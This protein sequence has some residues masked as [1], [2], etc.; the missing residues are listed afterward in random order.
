M[1][2]C[3][4]SAGGLRS[5]LRRRELSAVEAL[6]AVL[7]RADASPGRCTRSRSGST[8]ARG[9]G[10]GGRRRRSRAGTGGPLCGVPVTIK[11]SH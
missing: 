3:E 6:E 2:V 5:A 4:L 10:V 9:R 7:E 8:S 1:D 11:D